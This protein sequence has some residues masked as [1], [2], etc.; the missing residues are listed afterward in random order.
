MD[1]NRT[2]YKL[3]EYTNGKWVGGITTHK[4]DLLLKKYIVIMA[5]KT[6][7]KTVE[8]Q[9]ISSSGSSYIMPE[10]IEDDE[11]YEYLMEVYTQNGYEWPKE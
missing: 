8:M 2:I 3:R 4:Y 7:G 9:M 5:E 10:E 1:S 11:I 6:E